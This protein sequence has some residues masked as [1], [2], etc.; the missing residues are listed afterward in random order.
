LFD[1]RKYRANL[2]GASGHAEAVTGTHLYAFLQDSQ[3]PN[4]LVASRKVTNGFLHNGLSNTASVNLDDS[5]MS[6]S[7]DAKKA[8][9]VCFVDCTE[10]YF[11]IFPLFYSEIITCENMNIFLFLYT[12]F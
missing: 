12:I 3:L 8:F 1:P 5:Y 2:T 4:E 9:E 11:I 7:F 6:T 10:I